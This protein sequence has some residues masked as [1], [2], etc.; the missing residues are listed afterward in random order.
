MADFMFKIGDT[1][2]GECC[3]RSEKGFIFLRQRSTSTYMMTS[4]GATIWYGHELMPSSIILVEKFIPF[5]KDC[6]EMSFD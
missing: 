1:A 5:E 2:T 4:R 6:P 3:G